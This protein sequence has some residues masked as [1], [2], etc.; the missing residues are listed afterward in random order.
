MGLGA[1]SSVIHPYPTRAEAIR[2]PADAYTRAKL[3]PSVAGILEH[4]FRWTR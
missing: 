4:W 1:L 3:T 2:K